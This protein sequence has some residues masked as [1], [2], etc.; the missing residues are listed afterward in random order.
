MQLRT[1]VL[2]GGGSDGTCVASFLI[3]FFLS[4]CVLDTFIVFFPVCKLDVSAKYV[5]YD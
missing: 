4:P 1:W 3:R 2:G 5:W